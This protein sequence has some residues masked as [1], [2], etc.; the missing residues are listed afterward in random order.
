M[1]VPACLGA[2]LDGTG[3]IGVSAWVGPSAAPDSNFTASIM[4][5]FERERLAGDND[6]DLIGTSAGETAFDLAAVLHRYGNR[7]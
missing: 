7:L 2:G 6:L 1:V 5:R 3:L 4:G